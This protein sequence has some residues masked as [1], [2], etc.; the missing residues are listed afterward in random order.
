MRSFGVLRYSHLLSSAEF[1]ECYAYTRLGIC[2]G[3]I[4]NLDL[5]EFDKL[6]YLAMPAH[7][8]NME[9]DAANDSALRDKLRASIVK[10][11]FKEE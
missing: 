8:I 7:I 5:K 6:L 4:N 3:L 2:Q 11:V 10:E 9:A 1:F